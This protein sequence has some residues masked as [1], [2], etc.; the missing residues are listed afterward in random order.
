[1]LLQGLKDG[2][3]NLTYQIH[4]LMNII[5][6]SRIIVDQSKIIIDLSRNIVNLSK[7][8]IDLFVDY[9]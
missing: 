5:D 7:T 8:I 2:S 9:C 6:L 4:S 3:Q 1:M